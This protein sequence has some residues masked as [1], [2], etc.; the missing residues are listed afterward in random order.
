MTT[1]PALFT[2]DDDPKTYTAIELLRAK[3]ELSEN[4]E[5]LALMYELTERP[6][7][8]SVVYEGFNHPAF[9]ITRIN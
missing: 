1:T 2:I 8:T 5:I 4:S 3:N 6:V 7:A 9:T